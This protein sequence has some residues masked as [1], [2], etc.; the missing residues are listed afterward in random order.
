MQAA[1]RGAITLEHAEVARA[2]VKST[3][4]DERTPRCGA[5]GR[6]SMTLCSG[7]IGS[8]VK[9]ASVVPVESIVKDSIFAALEDSACA[10]RRW[11]IVR[12]RSE[13]SAAS[14]RAWWLCKL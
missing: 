3:R 1:H 13:V 7:A 6:L 8:R 4:S 10:T 12:K 11:E 9:T 2:R 5:T 14:K